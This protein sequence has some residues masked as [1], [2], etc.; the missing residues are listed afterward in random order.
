MYVGFFTKTH[1]RLTKV[2]NNKQVEGE[3]AQQTMKTENEF[4]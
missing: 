3:R 1:Q 4:T 2:S